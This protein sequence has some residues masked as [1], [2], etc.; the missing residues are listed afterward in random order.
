MASSSSAR[1]GLVRILIR[2]PTRSMATDL[3]SFALGFRIPGDAG[4]LADR[5]TW[6]G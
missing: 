2:S 6:K 1:S 5:S 4:F 3:T